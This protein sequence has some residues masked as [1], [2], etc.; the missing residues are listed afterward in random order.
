MEA[1]RDKD[2]IHLAYMLRET[3]VDEGQLRNLLEVG[4]R[5]DENLIRNLET[6]EKAKAVIPE[7]GAEER[8]DELQQ[9]PRV[10]PLE[11]IKEEARIETERERANK[12]RDFGK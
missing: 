12:G 4:S 5:H 11:Q 1:G 9:K 3:Y 6:L 10:S 8:R 7:L 2:L